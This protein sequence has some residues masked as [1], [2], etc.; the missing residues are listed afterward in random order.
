MTL[1]VPNLADFTREKARSIK[2]IG[3][4]IDYLT[5]YYEETKILNIPILNPSLQGDEN[6]GKL[7]RWDAGNRERLKAESIHFYVDDTKFTGVLKDPRLPIARTNAK[8][9]TE[10]NI[11]TNEHEPFP[12]SLFNIY[13]KRA[14]ARYW[15]EFGMKIFVDLNIEPHLFPIALEGVPKGWKSYVTRAKSEEIDLLINQYD[16]ARSHAGTNEINMH[17]IGGHYK[18]KEAAKSIGAQWHRAS[19][20]IKTWEAKA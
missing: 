9:F 5:Q 4:S 14:I 13:I 12:L 6:M 10:V 8:Q 11:S 20:E 3:K 16:L 18:G 1:D 15:Q 2:D 19:G 17:V 7:Y